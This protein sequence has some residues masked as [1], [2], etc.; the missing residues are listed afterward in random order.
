MPEDK[1]HTLKWPYILTSPPISI[2]ILLSENVKFTCCC[3]QSL[4]AGGNVFAKLFLTVL[5]DEKIV[6]I[7]FKIF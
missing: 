1:I 3:L 4:F 2:Y 5:E 6:A 7:I